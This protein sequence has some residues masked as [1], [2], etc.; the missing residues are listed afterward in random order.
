MDPEA[1]LARFLSPYEDWVAEDVPEQ[2]EQYWCAVAAGG[3]VYGIPS[4]AERVMS[5]M[6]S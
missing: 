3:K 6:Y 4:S 1:G 2:A 5:L